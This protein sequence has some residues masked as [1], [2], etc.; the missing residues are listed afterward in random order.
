MQGSD[1]QTIYMFLKTSVHFGGITPKDVQD[2]LLA[3]CS[4]FTPGGICKQ[5]EVLKMNFRLAI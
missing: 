3:L 5:Y 4:G 1:D 2:F